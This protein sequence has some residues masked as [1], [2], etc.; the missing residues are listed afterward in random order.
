M[1][2]FFKNMF[3]IYIMIM[4][5]LAFIVGIVFTFKGIDGTWLISIP[6]ISI[7][8]FLLSSF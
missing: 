5:L 4:N 1:E 7:A 2:K 3:I 6:L 8:M